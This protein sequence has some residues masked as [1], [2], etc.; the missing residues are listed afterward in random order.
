[1]KEV[2]LITPCF[3]KFYDFDSFNSVLLKLV[4]AVIKQL[5]VLAPWV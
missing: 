1:M 2:G 4:P 3:E 5:I